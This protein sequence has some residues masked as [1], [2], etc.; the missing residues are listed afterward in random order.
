MIRPQILIQNL[1]YGGTYV[2]IEGKVTGI[3]HTSGEKVVLNF[4]KKVSD[5]ENSK[6]T[7]TA[8]D[9]DG[10]EVYEIFGSWLTKIQIKHIDSG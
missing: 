3:N 1:I 7:G 8:Y 6:I 2:D 5:N 9:C 10:N 4:F